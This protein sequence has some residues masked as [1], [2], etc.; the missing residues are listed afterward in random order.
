MKVDLQRVLLV[1]DSP[2]MR[3]IQRAMLA[4]MGVPHIEEAQ[5]GQDALSRIGAF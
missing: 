3:N 1:D 5:D 4:Q 2:T